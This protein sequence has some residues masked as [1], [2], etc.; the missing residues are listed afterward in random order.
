MPHN[1]LLACWGAAGNLGPLLTAG[2]Q[3]RN[4]GHEFASSLI[5]VA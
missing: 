1:F 4:R 5:G 2:R 3:L